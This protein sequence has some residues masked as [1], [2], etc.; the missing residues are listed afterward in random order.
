MSRFSRFML[1]TLVALA[2]NGFAAHAQQGSKPNEHGMETLKKE[3]VSG[4]MIRKDERAERTSTV[5]D[6]GRMSK[7]P[8]LLRKEDRLTHHEKHPQARPAPRPKQHTTL[9]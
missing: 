8:K 9:E 3:G 5:R 6:D 2:S 7:K 4:K 1:A